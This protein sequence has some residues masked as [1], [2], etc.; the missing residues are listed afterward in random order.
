M[1]NKRTKMEK[2]RLW[3]SIIAIMLIISMVGSVAIP[4]FMF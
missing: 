3:A 2:K 1:K 4:F